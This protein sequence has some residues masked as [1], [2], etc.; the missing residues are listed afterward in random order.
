MSTV[1][2]FQVRQSRGPLRSVLPALSLLLALG[3]A[4]G[5]P[6]AWADQIVARIG[7]I[8]NPVDVVVSHTG[9]T[10]YVT[11]DGGQTFPG[12]PLT[13]RLVRLDAGRTDL[14]VPGG[15]SRLAI[16]PVVPPLVFQDRLYVVNHS[17]NTLEVV[18]VS[19]YAWVGSIAVGQGP[20]DVIFDPSGL[21]AY[22]TCSTDRKV[23]VVDVTLGP[24]G[25]VVRNIPLGNAVPLGLTVA[26]V[27][28]V[29]VRLYVATT[30]QLIHR[31]AVIDPAAAVPIVQWI[32]VPSQP[33]FLAATPDGSRVFVTM[34]NSTTAALST[35]TA[36]VE[37][38]IANSGDFPREVTVADTP[39]GLRAYVAD[40]GGNGSTNWDVTRIDAVSLTLLPPILGTDKLLQGIASSPDGRRVYVTSGFH[41]LDVIDTTLP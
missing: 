40:Q 14:K 3:L 1:P 35:A 36:Q 20:Y 39:N 29:G 18:G 8:I 24:V 26:N 17:L 34:K 41:R 22:V 27:P 30:D 4:L 32:S 16:R 21:Q 38:V 10:V 37:A 9:T 5:L 28:G 6:A 15:I 33:Y 13:A 12:D 23:Q 7:T 19:P 11:G 2:R 31:V 25:Q